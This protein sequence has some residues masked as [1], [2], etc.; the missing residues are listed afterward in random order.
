MSSRFSHQLGSWDLDL[1]TKELSW[2]DEVYAIFEMRKSNCPV[3]YAE[4]VRRIHPA[5]L[6]HLMSIMQYAILKGQ[7]YQ[8]EHRIVR[9]DGTERTVLVTG[10]VA[11]DLDDLVVGLYGTMQDIT[12]NKHAQDRIYYQAFHDN[13]TGLLNRIAFND[14]LAS[15]VSKAER[16]GTQVA[17]LFIDLDRFKY[18][19]DTY[20]HEAGDLLLKDTA[21]RIQACVTPECLAAR[22]GGDEFTILVPDLDHATSRA[23]LDDLG[24]RLVAALKEPY[25]VSDIQAYLTSS[26]GISCYPNDGTKPSDLLK[27]A[28]TAMYLAKSL[29]KDNYQFYTKE[30]TRDFSNHL[31]L[32]HDLRGALARNELSLHYQPMLDVEHDT[33]TGCEALLRWRHPT[34]GWISPGVFIPLAEETDLIVSLGEWVLEESCRQIRR[35]VEAGLPRVIVSVN[36]SPRQISRGGLLEKVREVLATTGVDPRCL[37]LELTESTLIRNLEQTR[38]VIEGLRLL[39]VRL[40]MD[41][42]GTGYSSL[43]YLARLKFD[44][45]K[46]DRSFVSNMDK[47]DDREIIKIIVAMGNALRY[48]IVAEGVETLE[49]LDFLKEHGCYNIQGY[50]FS[51]A[52][53]PDSF[54]AYLRRH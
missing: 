6:D 28:D 26:V 45:L 41:D 32:E 39:G 5:D 37:Q 17:V 35:W 21:R 40:S 20:G 46:I 48:K 27:A 13:L 4:Y 12:D 44:T 29:G 25:Q 10:R 15:A 52:L 22:L 50:L 18:V 43:S 30:D 2:S 31:I 3:K 33:V 7:S 42:F 38:E 23:A 11:T 36:V 1:A 16:E 24:T 47:E 34:H 19:N 53:D 9:T 49:Q 54:A 51:Q 8:V 14:R